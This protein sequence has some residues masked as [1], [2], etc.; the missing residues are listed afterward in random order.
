MFL[1]DI[2]HHVG[3]TVEGFAFCATVSQSH[4]RKWQNLPQSVCDLLSESV[5]PGSGHGQRS[6]MHAKSFVALGSTR[7][8]KTQVQLACADE[9]YLQSEGR[10][11]VTAKRRSMINKQ[12]SCMEQGHRLQEPLR[13]RRYCPETIE[14]QA[15]RQYKL[16]NLGNSSTD[17]FFDKLQRR[18]GE[19]VSRAK[20]CC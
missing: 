12:R 8:G 16:S 4:A 15:D 11:L 2:Q 3:R 10:Q 1:P 6:A 14:Q 5:L 19:A 7:C 17:N 9:S 13:V 20:L 18:C